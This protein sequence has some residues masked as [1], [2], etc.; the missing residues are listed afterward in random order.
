MDYLEALNWR[1]SVKKFSGERIP[2]AALARITEAARLSASSMGL[3]PYKMLVVEDTALKTALSEAFYQQH[4]V[5]SCSHLLIFVS[6]KT[7]DENYI[8]TYFNNIAET[9]GLLPNELRAF[10]NSVEG[11][12]QYM[13]PE[14]SEHWSDKQAYI[15]L[16]NV[17][18]AC[19]L[20]KLDTCPMEG[21]NRKMVEEILETDTENYKVA[22]AIAIGYRSAEDEFQH[23]KKVR[24][25][26][27]K[28]AKRL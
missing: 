26:L 17:L 4:Q 2:E 27:E 22:V 13:S 7:I 6:R 1:Y 5:E 18:L 23:L 14:E 8:D 11:F 19:A 3:Q 28:F 20:E 16:G 25:P 24:K 15:A 12:T 21:F 9:R 10:R